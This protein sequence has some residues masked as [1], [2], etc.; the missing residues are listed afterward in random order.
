MRLVSPNEFVVKNS[1][2]MDESNNPQEK[3]AK[4][5]G[6]TILLNLHILHR[7]VFLISLK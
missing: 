2:S 5:Y 6:Q 4:N 3:I 7:P 1:F